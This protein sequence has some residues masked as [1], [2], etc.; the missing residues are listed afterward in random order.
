MTSKHIHIDYEGIAVPEIDFDGDDDDLC[1]PQDP[2]PDCEIDYDD[3][4]VPEIHIS[5]THPNV[6]RND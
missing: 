3:V 1:E 4:A 5:L 2:D 6:K